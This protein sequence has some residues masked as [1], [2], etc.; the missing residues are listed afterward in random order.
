L[1]NNKKY[2]AFI[3][4]RHADNKEPGRQW[5]TWLH[6]AIETYEVPADLVGK[7]NGRGEIIPSRIFPIF[8]DEEE[9][10]ADANLGNSIKGA[11]E[12][13]EI[14]IV[15]CSPNAVASTYV[16]DEVDHFKKLGLS[17]RIIAALLYGEP[18]TSWDKG[19]LEGGFKVG[20]ECFPTPLQFEYDENGNPTEKRA[21][22]IAADFRINN[23]GKTEQGWTTI[24]AY[25]Q[26]LN[27][28]TQLSAKETQNKLDAY[29][30][31]QHLM[32]LK[33]IAGILGVPLGELTQ[34]DKEYQLELEKQKAKKLR[35]WLGIVFVLAVLATL[36][37]VFAYVQKN[38]S[39][40]LASDINMQLGKGQILNGE[41]SKGLTNL[42]NTF[43]LISVDELKEYWSYL[44]LQV[45]FQKPLQQAINELDTPTIFSWRGKSYLLDTQGNLKAVHS[46]PVT[47]AYVSK[48]DHMILANENGIISAYSLKEGKQLW[49]YEEKRYLSD[50][51]ISISNEDELI[52][53]ANHIGMTNGVSYGRKLTFS[54]KDFPEKVLVQRV[55][56]FYSPESKES[57][58]EISKSTK[59]LNW[60]IQ[61]NSTLLW[62][63]ADFSD[64]LYLGSNNQIKDDDMKFTYGLHL[65]DTKI[66]KSPHFIIG[67]S[68]K[69]NGGGGDITYCHLRR[70][71]TCKSYTYSGGLY[72]IELPSDCSYF[73]AY[74]GDG[75]PDGTSN[76]I[77]VIDSKGNTLPTFQESSKLVSDF[78]SISPS[79]DSFA[80]T[81]GDS[82]L[83]VMKRA[84]SKKQFD[85]IWK[86]Y[87]RYRIIALTMVS[88]NTIVYLDESNELHA[89]DILSNK[90]LWPSIKINQVN[91]LYPLPNYTDYEAMYPIKLIPSDKSNY[92]MLASQFYS[93]DFNESKLPKGENQVWS[94]LIH[95]KHGTLIGSN[96]SLDWTTGQD[97]EKYLWDKAL[98]IEESEKLVFSYEP[99][100]SFEL[101]LPSSSNKEILNIKRNISSY[102]GFSIGEDVEPIE[103][104]TK[105]Y[106][107]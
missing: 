64:H 7:K 38:K 29:Q 60:P 51:N 31:Q 10:P 42:F 16:A 32:L 41:I 58:I 71:A 54:I 67:A 99:F 20:D 35:R 52:I 70:D 81:D 105:I 102:T 73:V 95:A 106:K 5:A 62:E 30:K 17:N 25:K 86:H 100:A 13:T 1:N 78:L 53:V 75:F 6:Q 82:E 97:Y 104:L 88:D 84:N 34:R 12:S 85:Q 37:G 103:D 74:G 69:R 22:P 24:E 3:S 65:S 4:Y 56:P 48:L 49:S 19:K 72:S 40:K 50:F 68:D 36:A 46:N 14:L 43:N 55:A 87:S 11:L 79:G 33:I 9:L 92:I 47:F 45:K 59:E 80:S 8:R 93:D 61:N 91:K 96:I 83:I 76:G 66:C 27:H 90:N 28:T 77:L 89:Y 21:E 15:L 94:Q 39:V 2:H 26:H 101:K 63:V 98:L 57:I 44:I 107:K 23:D 18:N